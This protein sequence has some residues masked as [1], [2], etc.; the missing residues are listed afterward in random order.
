MFCVP[1]KNGWHLLQTS[2]RIDSAVEPT[3][4][5]LPHTQWTCA[6]WNCGWISAFMGICAPLPASG[7]LVFAS[8]DADALLVSCR[9][10]E[11]DEAIGGGEERV[12]TPH[13]DV[14][15]G[16][17]GAAALPDDDRPAQHVLPV[18]A[19][20]PES[21]AGAVAPIPAGRAG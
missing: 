17:E 2:T 14:G 19:L 3:V 5:V 1:V 16:V 21:L 15:A 6:S 7:G 9:V 10:G 11:S 12:V 4:K 8:F 20:D 18:A 13:P